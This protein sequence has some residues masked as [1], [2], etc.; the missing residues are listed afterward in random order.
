M[1]NELPILFDF[2]ENHDRAPTASETPGERE[3]PIIPLINTVLFPHMLAPLFVSR[4]RSVA[5]IEEAMLHDRL[6]LAIAQ[7]D[8]DVDDVAPGDL[9]TVGVEALVQR[10]L[11][12]PDGTTSVVIQGQ[13]RMRVLELTQEIPFLSGRAV[14]I[15]SQEEHSLSVEAMMRAVLSL[16]EK[17]VR[18]SRT[19]PDDSYVMAMNVDEPGWLA[20][21]IASTLP[22]DVA[23]RQEILETLDAEERLRRL[24]IMLSKELDVLELESRIH[25]QVQKE[26]DRSQR[27]FFLREQLK[28]IQRELGQLDPVQ[29][30]LMQLRE[31]IWATD[32]PEKVRAKALEELER[33]EMM[34][35]TSPE[36]S[37]IR[38]YLD[39]LL[40]LPWTT[41]TEDNHDLRMAAKTLEVNHYGLPRVKERILEFIAVRQL[42]GSRIKSPI[43]CFVGPPGVGKTSLGRS[44]AEALGRTFARLSLGGVHDE[45][46][47]RGHRRTY[48]GSLPGRIIQTMKT[49][50]T[51]NPVFM[52]DEV[53]KLGRDFRGDPASALL[54]VLDPEQ[55]NS[56]SDH[57]LDV[58]YDLSKVFFITTANLLY[59]IPEALLDRMEVIELPGY[60]EEEKLH[61]ARR[62]LIPR[63]WEANGLPDNSLRF[64]DAA[65]RQLIR[66]YTYEA[67][68]RNLEREIGTLCR[69]IAR[70]MAEQRPHARIVRPSMLNHYLGP[71]R[72]SYGM[73]EEDDE[74]G[75]STSMVWTSNG[76]DIMAIEVTLMPGKGNLTLT[77]QLGE[78]MQESAQAA[79]SYARTNAATLHIDS[80]RFD[81]VDIH[82]HVPEGA[83]PKDG[84]SAG[85]TLAT[86][87]ISAFADRRVR[88]DVAMTGE[89]TLRGRVLPVGGLKEK[90][91]G[92]YRAGIHT[93]ILP[94]RNERDIADV[95]AS[96]RRKMHFIYVQHMD[97]VLETALCPAL[98]KKNT[99]KSR[100]KRQRTRQN[101][102]QN[103][104]QNE[105]ENNTVAPTP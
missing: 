50:G 16:F 29:R 62:F 22:L 76:G 27:E 85:I 45:A 80:R 48:I 2:P 70:R 4:E 38:T 28:A 44:I 105:D 30:E 93:I 54:E 58:H 71:P 79:H 10:V 43:L 73:A 37:V 35:T 102:N 53:D 9:Y 87:L 20:D 25:N 18:L 98:P 59:P 34:P 67:G 13:R 1:P 77:G 56:F 3:I 90:I 66:V 39:W 46:E 86:A 47:I 8:P 95:P 52:L 84:P 17:V 65:L 81:K 23:H 51:I 101:Q 96:V 11:R 36:Y 32:M 88:R 57:Y 60:I 69:K 100:A 49:V 72:Y 26:V 31:R 91:L 68:V 97:E 7:R 94:A 103:Q 33:M 55:N 83:V 14:P 15:Y 41:E 61:I 92:A 42:A 24:S 12:M 75:V 21:L 89:I 6:V 63:Q 5:A 82:I 40:D 99:G 64:S 74:V 19:M 104:N 78:V